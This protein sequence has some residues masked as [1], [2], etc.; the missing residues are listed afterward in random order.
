[1]KSYTAMSDEGIEAVIDKYMSESGYEI[2][3]SRSDFA[4]LMRSLQFVSENAGYDTEIESWAFD[5]GSSIAETL[6]VEFI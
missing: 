6:G 5:F 1:M 3:F 2:R 4:S